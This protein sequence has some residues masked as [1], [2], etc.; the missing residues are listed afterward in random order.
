MK[1]VEYLKEKIEVPRWEHWLNESLLT[2]SALIIT[3][4]YFL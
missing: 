3:L 2:L 4:D 1:T